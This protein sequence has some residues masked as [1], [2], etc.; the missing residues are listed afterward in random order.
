MASLTS[1][2]V[3]AYAKRLEAWLSG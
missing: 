2:S 3:L 1:Y